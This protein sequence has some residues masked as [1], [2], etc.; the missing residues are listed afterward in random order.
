MIHLDACLELKDLWG[1]LAFPDEEK[2]LGNTLEGLF[3]A[4]SRNLPVS[5]EKVFSMN[6][7]FCLSILMTCVSAGYL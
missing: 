3:L 6:L 7:Y 5:G 2:G 4:D 1:V